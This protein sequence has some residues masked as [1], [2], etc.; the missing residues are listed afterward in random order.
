MGACAV[1]GGGARGC[2]GGLWRRG[3]RGMQ[4]LIKRGVHEVPHPLIPFGCHNK[5]VIHYAVPKLCTKTTAHTSATATHF[6]PIAAPTAANEYPRK[7]RAGGF[8]FPQ[9]F[10]RRHTRLPSRSAP[11]TARCRQPC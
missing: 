11:C 4:V 2:C 3:T 10:P 8:A 7:I 1:G 6:I 5:Y 9:T